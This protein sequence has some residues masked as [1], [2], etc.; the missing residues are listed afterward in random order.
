MIR[1]FK[2]LIQSII[3]RLRGDHTTEQL[4]KAG[5][6][7]GTNFHRMIGV[8]IDP[9]HC[10]HIVI[11]DNVTLAPRVHILAHDASTI[12]HLGYAK[13]GNINIGNNVFVG[14]DS[15][16]LPCVTIGHDSIIGANSTV[17]HDIPPRTV[18]AGQPA[19]IICPLDEFLDKHRKLM[20]SRPVFGE[21]Y[22]VRSH[23]SIEM[24]HDMH[25]KLE[26]GGPGYI[27]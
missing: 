27:R 12:N 1:K 22:S 6:K 4:I 13:I 2:Q 16:I 9:A 24:L 18:A 15:I 21:E 23:P 17:T 3:F 25:N 5:L 11:G 8:I 20:E 10:H 7:V 26:D 19:R 14:A